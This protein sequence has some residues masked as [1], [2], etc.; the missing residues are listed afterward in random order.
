MEQQKL[1]IYQL[2][3]R[4]FGNEKAH[5]TFNGSRGENGCGKFSALTDKALQEFKK[6]GITHLWLT[7]VIEHAV[8]EGYPAHAIPHGNELIIK[9]KAGSPYAIKDYYDVHPDL[10]EDVDN[11]MDEFES[12]LARI[13]AAGMKVIIDF[14][15]NHLARQ[16]HSDAKPDALED[17]GEQDDTSVSFSQQNNFYYLPGQALELPSELK[18]KFSKVSYSEM[19]AKATGNDRFTATPS[20]T[21]WYET[22]K[23]NYGVDYT[24]G[25]KKCFSPLPDTWLKMKH[26]LNYWVAK[27]VD[28][29]RCDMAE[30]VPVQFWEWLIAE[31]RQTAPWLIFIAEVYNPKLY[32]SY[33]LQGQFDYL[34]DKVGLYDTLIGVIKGEQPAT[35]ISKCWQQLEG[36]DR[37]MLRFMENHDEQRLASRFVVGEPKRAIPAMAVAAF[38]HQGPVMLYN[39]QEFGEKGEGPCGFSG[40]DGRTSIFDYW[41][42]PEHQKWMNNGLFDGGLLSDDQQYLR[43]KYIDITLLC[44]QPAISQGLFYDVMWQNKD[45]VLFDSQ[46]VYAFI[47]YSDTQ[48]LIVVCN[49]D[50]LSKQMNVQVP[51]HAFETLNIPRPSRLHFT[52]LNAVLVS[53]I[54]SEEIINQGLNI[55]V[56][57]WDYLVLAFS[58]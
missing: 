42:L 15:P 58:Y 13:H 22:V 19:P 7:G 51:A 20:V 49:F 39:G 8:V 6:M 11:R 56:P 47:R 57:A 5:M 38:M 32:K 4:L 36:L 14:V 1:V 2:L 16:Y 40:D 9:G 41:H 30:M 23:L 10:A 25:N 44:A 35:N 26:I 33:I 37:H 18:S 34:Y 12:L 54:G 53:D 45:N 21:D 28:G 31:L 43:Q 48:Q 27:G 3:P 24:A 46:K 52:A 17:F 29:F 55:R 50:S